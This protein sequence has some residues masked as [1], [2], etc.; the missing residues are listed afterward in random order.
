MCIALM[1]T[2]NRFMAALFAGKYLSLVMKFY[3]S[4][5]RSVALDV[6]L[7]L[8]RQLDLIQGNLPVLSFLMLTGHMLKI[9]HIHITLDT[10]PP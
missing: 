5:G 4:C 7:N 9:R 2:S 10:K 3:E 8:F 1:P 6:V